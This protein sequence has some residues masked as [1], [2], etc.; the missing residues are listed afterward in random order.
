MDDWDIITVKA[1]VHPDG[2]LYIEDDKGTMRF[3]GCLQPE[4]GVI[5]TV[6]P[7]PVYENVKK[8]IDK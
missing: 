6:L 3:V 5:S 7:N 1:D 4:D 2:D 8:I